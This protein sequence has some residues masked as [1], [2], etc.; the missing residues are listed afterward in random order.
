MEDITLR[1]IDGFVLADNLVGMALMT[2]VAIFFCLGEQQ[3]QS[4]MKHA[5][6]ELYLARLAKEATSQLD[7]NHPKIEYVKNEYHV[8]ATYSGVEINHNRQ[9]VLTV[10]KE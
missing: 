3:L 6:Q 4:Q 1:K 8:V 7:I 2:M 5:K 9:R 10:K